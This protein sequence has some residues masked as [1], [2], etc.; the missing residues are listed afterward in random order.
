MNDIEN[1]NPQEQYE[2]LQEEILN[3]QYYQE[4]IKL[5][6]END[7][8][9]KEKERF[10]NTEKQLNAFEKLLSK[11][12]K[13]DENA[14]ET[15]EI[16]QEVDGKEVDD[17][18]VN[19][20]T[21]NEKEVNEKKIED[22]Q[23]KII[24]KQKK[25]KNAVKKG[26]EEKEEKELKTK[27]LNELNHYLDKYSIVKE[28]IT[29]D[30]VKNELYETLNSFK[31]KNISG[32][33]KYHNEKTDEVLEF[34]EIIQKFFEKPHVQVLVKKETTSAFDNIMSNNVNN[35]QIPTTKISPRDM[36]LKLNEL[37]TSEYNEKVINMMQ[38]IRR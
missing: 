6:E 29:R 30:R 5:Q 31:E 25:E 12:K 9:E 7:R 36:E 15:N 13:G 28:D 4:K 3:N 14:K 27:K 35:T 16:K 20:E 17:K 21:P 38:Q 11:F 22:K 23:T 32:I 1:P 10:L 33:K 2:K 19:D 37:P 8:K 24:E 26:N 18:K 34:N